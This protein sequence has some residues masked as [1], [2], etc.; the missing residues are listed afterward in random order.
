MLMYTYN[1]F[2]IF[3][4]G[5]LSQHNLAQRPTVCLD[6]RHIG[7]TVQHAIAVVIVAAHLRWCRLLE[8][9]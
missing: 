6:Q 9:W 8:W 3:A 7:A 2:A 5:E 1:Q 4:F